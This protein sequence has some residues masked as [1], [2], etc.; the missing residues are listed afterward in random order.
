MNADSK[1]TFPTCFS[2]KARTVLLEG[3]AYF[4]VAKNPDMPFVVKTDKMNTTALG[5]EFNVKAYHGAVP[6]V[7]LVEGVVL[8][9]VPE[10]KKNVRLAPSEEI[11][12]NDKTVNIRNIDPQYYIQWKDGFFYYDNVA[13]G[14]ILSDIGRWYN[15][16]IEIEKPALMSYRL[17]FVVNRDAVIDEVINSLNDFTYLDAVKSGNK[18]TVRGKN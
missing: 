10:V 6:H 3:E 17:H 2:G 11:S 1:L 5:T 13:L 18:I 4:K 9:D 7:T 16:N 12:L 8:V 15:I 14:E